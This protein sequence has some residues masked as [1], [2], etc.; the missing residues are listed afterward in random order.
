MPGATKS[1]TVLST[2][3][4]VI[5]PA[6]IRR[7]QSWNP[8]IRLTVEETLDGVLLRAAPAFPPTS[9]EQVFGCLH[10]QDKPKTLRDM[11]DG[12]AAEVQRRHARGR[13]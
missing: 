11:R 5:V 1:V 13:Y 10:Y 4:Q 2:K 12:I 6:A 3:G 9:P 8:G 7:R